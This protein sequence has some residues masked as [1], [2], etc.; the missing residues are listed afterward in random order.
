MESVPGY[1]LKNP[2]LHMG[3][4]EPIKRG[5]AEILYSANDGVCLRETVSG[6]YM[7]SVSSQKLGRELLETL[8]REG[9]FTF[10]QACLLDDFKRKVRCA[11]LLENYQA[12]YVRGKRL[13]VS[14]G[15]EIKKLDASYLQTVLDNYDYAVGAEYLRGRLEAG[16]L[17]GGCVENDLAGFT[18]IHAEGS[19]GLLKVFDRYR[20]NGYGAALTSFIV[21]RQ[22]ARRITPFM[23]ISVDNEAS[24]ALARSLGFCISSEKMYWLF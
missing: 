18:G 13:H 2:L 7:M 10:H 9:I 6:A 11:T 12:V 19:I 22:L 21:N 15:M 4:I 1:L 3:M 24:L 20:R 8:P 17:F 16:E 23:Q 14:A 5:T